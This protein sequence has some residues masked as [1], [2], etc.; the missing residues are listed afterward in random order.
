MTKIE[1]EAPSVSGPVVAEATMA[2]AHK[3]GMTWNGRSGG[4]GADDSYG[5]HFGKR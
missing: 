1:G 2:N 4:N 3:Y 5:V